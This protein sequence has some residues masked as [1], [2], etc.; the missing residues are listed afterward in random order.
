[1]VWRASCYCR[2]VQRPRLPLL[3]PKGC[4]AHSKLHV[5]LD[6]RITDVL[7]R[8][9]QTVNHTI[10]FLDVRTGVYTK[11]IESTCWHVKV[12]LSP[13]NRIGWLR[14]STSPQHVLTRYR[15]DNVDQFFTFIDIVVMNVVI[16]MSCSSTH[17][18]QPQMLLRTLCQP[19][20]DFKRVA[21]HNA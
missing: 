14:L 2:P 3:V 20:D 16:S 4:G 1:M 18:L 12:F 17:P 15:S 6:V 7:V 21:I 8:W 13:Y 10:G 19:L 5:V 9:H 11:T